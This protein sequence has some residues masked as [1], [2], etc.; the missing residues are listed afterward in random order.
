MKRTTRRQPA[1]LALSVLALTLIA[2]WGCGQ[3]PDALTTEQRLEETLRQ[4]EQGDA[5]AQ[6]S[7]GVMYANG[8]SVPQDYQ[9]AMKWF[10]MAAGQGE[11]IAQTYLGTMYFAG[12]GVSQDYQE[13]ESWWRKAAEQGN[14]DAQTFLG[15]MYADGL[16]VPQD[17]QEAVSWYRMAAEQ[18]FADAQYNLG[19]MYRNGKGVAQDDQE[20]L[21]WYRMGRRAGVRCCPIQSRSHVRRRPERVPG[22]RPKPTSGLTWQPHELR[23]K[24]RRPSD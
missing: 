23:V 2:P 8:R 17:D 22:L 5:E 24:R 10:R 3:D 6:F 16:G 14:A 13:A 21:K 18:G 4:A 15:A 12:Q 1:V 9:E 7:L 19:V 20:A 11:A